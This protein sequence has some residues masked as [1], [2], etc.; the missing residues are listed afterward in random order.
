MNTAVASSP[1]IDIIIDSS[2]AQ[3]GGNQVVAQLNRIAAAGNNLNGSL[4]GTA[5]ALGGVGNAASGM[6]GKLTAANNN[7]TGLA[8]ILDRLKGAAGGATSSLSGL[9][10]GFSG[11]GS[12]SLAGVAAGGAAIV[13]LGVAMAGAAS[14][15]EA[16]KASL[17]TVVGDTTKAGQAFDAL[18]AFAQ[19]TPFSLDQAVEGFIKLKALGLTPSENALTSYGNTASAMGKSLNQMVEAVADAATGEF[20]R[21]KEFGI[22]SKQQGD[23]VSFTF[24]GVTT[25]V[26]KSSEDIQK[27]LLAIGNTKFA[28]AMDRQ[29]ATIG[30]ALSGLSDQIFIL[31]AKMGEGGFSTALQGII[32]GITT[33][34]QRLT[35]LFVGIGA[36]VGGVV[37]ILGG[38]G[39]GIA[40][41]FG[42]ITGEG[43][44]GLSILDQ[45]TIAFGLVGQTFTV[46]GNLIGS[47]LRGIAAVVSW[48]VGG[49]TTMFDGAFSWL[50]GASASTTANMGLS[51]I[52]VL[53][54]VK[55]VAQSIPELFAIAFGDVKKLFSNL[56]SIIG[57][58]LT[59]DVSALGDVGKAFSTSFTASAS[60]MDQ[61][62]AKAKSIAGDAKGAQSTVDRMLGR[63]QKTHSIDEFSG[64]SPKST[65]PAGKKEKE[66]H[67]AEKLQNGID[68]YWRTLNEAV[69]A[70]GLLPIEAEKLT[71][72][73]DLQNIYA[74][75]K[76]K[77]DGQA[78]I[79]AKGKI[80]AALSEI[81]LNKSLVSMQDQKLKLD[82]AY[83]VSTS[84]RIGLG[85]DEQ[86]IEDALAAHRVEALNSG[87]TLVDL[88]SE[89][90]KLAENDL[91]TALERA[92]AQD[93]L[94]DAMK[95]GNDIASKYDP[96]YD[97]DQRIQSINKDRTTFTSVAGMSG[98]SEEAQKSVL[99]GMDSAIDEINN[100]TRQKFATT[101][102]DLA[103]QFHGKF[104]DAIGKVAKLFQALADSSQGKFS[105]PLGAI[106]SV[107]GKDKNGAV[108][109]GGIGES[110]QDASK[111]IFDS[112]TGNNGKQSAFKAPLKSMSDGFG[113]FKGDMKGLFGKGGSFSSSLGSL[114]GKASAGAG[115]GSAVAG[116]GN[117]LG[118]K[119][120]N[121]GS[122]VGGALGSMVGGP[123]GSII[124]SIAGGIV[125]NLFKKAKYASSSLQIVN[126]KLVA[127]D[128]V[129]NSSKLKD[130][131]DTAMGS[132]V[133]GLNSIASQLGATISGTPSVSIGQYKDNWRV[134]DAGFQGKLNF[135]GSSAIGLHDFGDDA[136]AAVSYAIK[137]ALSD[138]ILTGLSDFSERLLKSAQDVDDAVDLASNYEKLL[139]NLE[140]FDNPLKAA[141]EAITK[142][143][144]SLITRMTDAGATTTELANAERYRQ[145]Q[146]DAVLKDQ[147]SSLTDLKK[148]LT[149]EGSGKTGL[150]RLTDDLSEFQQYKSDIGAGKTI[151]KDAFSSLA[152]EINN[153]AGSVY[154]TST[155]QF[156]SINSMLLDA[157]N[158]AIDSVTNEFNDLTAQAIKTQTDTLSAQLAVN[159]DLLAQQ[160]AATQAM[161]ASLGVSVG[162]V[163]SGANGKLTGT[164]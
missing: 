63:N 31:F 78:L 124:G 25:K 43:S 67:S 109:K 45:L 99:R 97:R 26:G 135:K 88:A 72:L 12:I 22:K 16:Y 51:F 145:L 89:K 10:Q 24:Q 152:Q 151:D 144:D 75:A 8:A 164:Y 153:L 142:P 83:T 147:L 61:I 123:I 4:G 116:V 71:K 18:A 77:L 49:I 100:E 161:A 6:A 41:I 149:G 87:A 15:V 68:K 143:L 85:E 121:T 70:S 112:I 138:G 5:G 76:K 127:G 47:G 80:D 74:N 33:G 44:K 111:G 148:F 48:L 103:S 110:Y 1:V 3:K 157:T 65:P 27:Y 34:V 53:K 81:A 141:V 102:D 92:A 37:S 154:G 60:K 84:K 146:L 162:S 90:W 50:G 69:A 59:G 133:S 30:G 160:L 128:A 91:K 54:A 130:S 120:S 9:L 11:L 156:A 105:G 134:S 104:G 40:S 46:V 155:S 108:I 132:V 94:N 129:G 113:S 7:S 106:A 163:A 159:N 17:T 131:A 73:Q 125:G 101:I 35:P 96:S 137:Q 56:G 57:R 150:A 28:G 114:M 52:G 20:E 86:K 98:M 42:A 38:L 93:K 119:L 29:T 62:A 139:S 118:L 64:T 36:V 13:A 19:K 55:F 66:D 136:E 32:T 39:S 158:G 82:N 23:S 122:Q 140:A 126:G 58:L 79:D 21:L 14:K 117:A 95:A 107:L 115:I 2:S